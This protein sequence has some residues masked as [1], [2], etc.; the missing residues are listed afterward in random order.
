[1]SQLALQLNG[2]GLHGASWQ[3]MLEILRDIAA[4]VSIKEMSFRLDV[5]PSLLYQALN[6][7]ERHHFRCEWIVAFISAAPDDT[8]VAFLAELRGLELAPAKPVTPAE[9]LAALHTV[10][11]E[12]LGA[13]IRHALL[14]KA[15]RRTQR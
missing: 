1:V 10:L 2:Q 14:A 8:L 5:A 11:E 13:E 7:T 6:Q 12:S 9:E 3:R 4:H 15:K